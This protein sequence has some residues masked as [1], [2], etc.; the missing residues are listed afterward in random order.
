[1]RRAEGLERFKSIGSD[2]LKGTWGM[3]AGVSNLEGWSK[4]LKSSSVNASSKLSVGWWLVYVAVAVE[5]DEFMSIL[6]SISISM[7]KSISM[8][9][10]M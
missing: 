7:A 2:A 1:M 4:K 9:I 5:R 6:K 3:G 10:S 8:F